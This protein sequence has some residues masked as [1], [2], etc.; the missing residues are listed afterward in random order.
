MPI[1][2]L[3]IFGSER[4]AGK[5]IDSEVYGNVEVEL[6]DVDKARECDVVFLAVD[7][8]FA[9]E[10]AKKISEGDDGAVVIDNSVSNSKTN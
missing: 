1:D 4:S 6:F 5:K 9:L 10:N 8:S 7:G 3:R 2:N